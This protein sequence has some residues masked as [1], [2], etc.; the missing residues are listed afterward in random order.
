MLN[1]LK[2]KPSEF[3]PLSRGCS[4]GLL[5]FG[6]SFFV[7]VSF[8]DTSMPG[9]LKQ[10]AEQRN[11]YTIRNRS[12]SVFG[13][14]SNCKGPQARKQIVNPINEQRRG[15]RRIKVVRHSLEPSKSYGNIAASL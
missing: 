1:V 14:E 6:V 5:K 9:I 10:H 7:L 11:G 2:S 15:R 12:I 3:A 8:G 4:G 13:K